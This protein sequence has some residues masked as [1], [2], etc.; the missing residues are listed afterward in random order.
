MEFKK[1]T[2]IWEDNNEPPKSYIWAKPDG[3]FYEY[4]TTKGWTESKLISSNGSSSENVLSKFNEYKE[5]LERDGYVFETSGGEL[6]LLPIET[7]NQMKDQLPLN[8]TLYGN[9]ETAASIAACIKPNSENPEDLESASYAII[10]LS[11]EE[12]NAL[13]K[14]AIEKNSWNFDKVWGGN[15][16]KS[17]NPWSFN[18]NSEL[19]STKLPSMYENCMEHSIEELNT[20]DLNAGTWFRGNAFNSIK[21]VM[22]ENGYNI[23]ILIDNNNSFDVNTQIIVKVYNENE[24]YY[25][26][27][28]IVGGS[29]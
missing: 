11:E 18:S 2:I 8:T 29:M 16:F 17:I 10:F 12:A 6:E 27:G 3:K 5:S 20:L 7:Y 26:P 15:E 14:D 4:N 22:I 28:Q 13:E 21:N 19:A 25:I 9:P 1:K 24:T 23:L